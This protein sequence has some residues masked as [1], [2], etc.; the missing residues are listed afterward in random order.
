MNKFAIYPLVVLM[1][2]TFLGQGVLLAQNG[3]V[4]EE[5]VNIEKVFIEASREK[6][7][8]NYENAATL[9]KE[10]LKRDNTNSAAAYELARMYDVLDKDSK[11]LTSIQMAIRLEGDNPWYRMFKA[12]IHDKLKQYNQAAKVYEALAAA[13]PNNSFFHSKWAYYLVKAKEPQKA[14]EVYDKLEAISGLSEELARKKHTLYLGMGDHENAAAIYQ[15]LIK[16]YPSQV[17]YYHYLADYYNHAGEKTLAIQVY[18]NILQI[19]PDDSDAQLALAGKE[20]GSIDDISFLSTLKPIFENDEV[21]IDAKIKELFPFINKVVDTRDK[22]LGRAVLQLSG[23]VEEVHPK[24]AKGFSASGDVLF[25]IGDLDAA[26]QK[27]NQA[28]DLNTSVFAVWEQVMYIYTEQE[29]YLA[30][31]N[32]TERSF[33][34]FP[35]QAK[36]YYFNGIANAQ[37]GKNKAAINS[38]RQALMMSRKN[39]TLQQDIYYRLGLTYYGLRQFDKSDKAF[40]KALELNPDNVMLLNNYSYHLAKRGEKLQQAKEMAEHCNKL[41]PDNASFQETYGWV[42]YKLK[43]YEGAKSW[44]SKSIDNGGNNFPS[45][46]EHFG[47]VLFQLGDTDQ[48][49]EYWQQARQKGAKSELLDKKIA[50]KELYE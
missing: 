11:A 46:L 12:D 40:D 42:L 21:E 18:E 20:K 10:V 47:D 49:L 27:Y 6:I 36:A 19:D 15:R 4:T 29:D 14:L 45:T 28:I 17:R 41:R 39:P 32:I 35:N 3:R 25:H 13:E 23:I 2:L 43:D 37:L 38:W 7:L 44:I 22:T 33:D 5:E 26:L 50:D 48:A 30:L 1:S 16:A 34:Y 31:E 24:D 9:Y 8:G